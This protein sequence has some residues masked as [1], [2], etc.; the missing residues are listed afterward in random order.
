MWQLRVG[1]RV[2][3][4]DDVVECSFGKTDHKLQAYRDDI[5]VLLCRLQTHLKTFLFIARQSAM[6]A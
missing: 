1:F 6:Q 4:V 2:E 3:F 5:I